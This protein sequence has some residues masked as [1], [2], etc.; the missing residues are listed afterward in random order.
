[1]VRI[2]ALEV[3]YGHGAR[4]AYVLPGLDLTIGRGTTMGLVGESGSGK[5][6]L[7]KAL[8][9]LLTPRSGE[10]TIDGVDVLGPGRPRRIPPSLVQLIPQDPYSS[11]NPRQ[12]V[13]QAI[14]EAI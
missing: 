1:M 11:L 7:A 8:V 12:T 5:S 9:G 13:G 6:T 14:A 3:S 4:T 10:I 2:R